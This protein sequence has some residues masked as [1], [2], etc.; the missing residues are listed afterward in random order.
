MIAYSLKNKNLK[1]IKEFAKHVVNQWKSKM[2]NHLVILFTT[3]Q[4]HI[5]PKCF[6]NS[7]FVFTICMMHHNIKCMTLVAIGK[8]KIHVC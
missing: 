4:K 3:H 2:E 1:N 7:V 6:N 8:G 5:T